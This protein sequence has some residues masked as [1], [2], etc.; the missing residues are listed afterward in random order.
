MLKFLLS[1][2]SYLQP[3]AHCTPQAPFSTPICIS[4]SAWERDCKSWMRVISTC[5]LLGKP[6]TC[7]LLKVHLIFA[8][9]NEGRVRV[10]DSLN[11][12]FGIPQSFLKVSLLTLLSFVFKKNESFF[13]LHVF[14]W[15]VFF[16][17]LQLNVLCRGINGCVGC[18][19]RRRP[20]AE[21]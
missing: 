6:D 11:S 21:D 2:D 16:L 18:M 4:P 1:H 15:N 19:R 10:F 12:M 20:C 14:L 7:S 17:S 8:T 3:W 5:Q 9:L 13:S